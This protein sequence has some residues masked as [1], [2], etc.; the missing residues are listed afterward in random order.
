MPASN[1]LSVTVSIDQQTCGRGQHLDREEKR[2]AFRK[3]TIKARK[4]YQATGV[5]VSGD[6]VTAW[7]ET[8][9]EEDEVAAPKPRSA[10]DA[11]YL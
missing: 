4:E 11:A 10:G 8:W 9:G 2:D 6:E 5:H 3:D 7:L 1:K